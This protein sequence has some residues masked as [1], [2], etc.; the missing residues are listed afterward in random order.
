MRKLIRGLE[1]AMEGTTRDTKALDRFVDR[2]I[3]KTK[4]RIGGD[5][6]ENGTIDVLIGLFNN[7]N[8]Q[9]S[10]ILQLKTRIKSERMKNLE[11][12]Q[13]LLQQDRTM[14]QSVVAQPPPTPL[15]IAQV[16]RQV[17]D[18]YLTGLSDS[19]KRLTLASRF[20]EDVLNR[21]KT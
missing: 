2:L 7:L 3:Q 21:D 11:M 14:R 19:R 6:A 20:Y 5:D 1:L 10:K 18:H 4:Q 17:E 15:S 8:N 16:L 12:R 13:W 9:S